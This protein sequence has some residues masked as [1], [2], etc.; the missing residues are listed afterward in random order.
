MLRRGYDSA[1]ASSLDVCG[2]DLGRTPVPHGR[3]CAE[4]ALCDKQICLQKGISAAQRLLRW[5]HSSVGRAPALQGDEPKRCAFLRFRRWTMSAVP[6]FCTEFR[7]PESPERPDR[8]PPRM[9][10]LAEAKVLAP[11]TGPLAGAEFAQRLRAHGGYSTGTEPG[12]CPARATL[13]CGRRTGSSPSS[14]PRL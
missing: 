2:V 11:V 1:G 5:G 6:E 13:R 7:G 10:P 12:V 3:N 8:A 14:S 9:K 4:F